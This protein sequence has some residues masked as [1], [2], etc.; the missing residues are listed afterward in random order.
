MGI[1]SRRLLNRARDGEACRGTDPRT[2]PGLALGALMAAAAEIGRDKLT[3]LVPDRLES[4]GLWVEQLVAES[5][6][7]QGKGIVPI[8]GETTNAPPGN[9]R[10]AI[11]VRHR[12]RRARRA[13]ASIGCAR[14]A[15]P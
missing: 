1:D 12:R 2:N 9:D 5:T 14:R 11:V 10:L 6:G 15:C 7:K 4:F 8:A 3:L 13:G